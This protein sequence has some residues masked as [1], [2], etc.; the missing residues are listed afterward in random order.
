MRL[1]VHIK[2]GG[3]D[4]IL[5][6]R[7]QPPKP[8]PRVAVCYAESAVTRAVVDRLTQLG[9]CTPLPI[10]S[11]ELENV[12]WFCRKERPDVLLLETVP[13]AMERFD[14]PGKD[15]A[16]R[17]E[18]AARVREERPDCRVYLICAE[19]FRRLEPVM[20]KAVDTR[21]IDGYCFGALTGQLIESWLP[22]P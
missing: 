5:R 15:I 2:G 3:A 4:L 9:F 19:E 21:L 1:F 13:D 8:L 22:P 7:R 16:G 11:D 14:D 17:C 20:Q 18:T 6:K 12:L 10:L